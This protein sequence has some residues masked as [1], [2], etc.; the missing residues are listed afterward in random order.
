MPMRR[1]DLLMDARNANASVNHAIKADL[2]ISLKDL[3]HLE[4]ALKI[5]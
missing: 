5:E 4:S 3:D 2:A 1:G